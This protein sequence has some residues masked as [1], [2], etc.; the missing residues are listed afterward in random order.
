[1]SRTAPSN[2]VQ[3]TRNTVYSEVDGKC[4]LERKSAFMDPYISRVLA[5]NAA[6]IFGHVRCSSPSNY[7]THRSLPTAEMRLDARVD[8]SD[9]HVF[10]CYC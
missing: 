1:M 2:S 6:V 5:S 8:A 3:E 7:K 10:F 9:S 4:L